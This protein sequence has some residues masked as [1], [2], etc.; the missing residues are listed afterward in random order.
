MIKNKLF[1]NT[2]SQYK[3]GMWQLSDQNSNEGWSD[4]L[5]SL[6]GLTEKNI[7]PSLEYF[8][9][10]ILHPDDITFFKIC[11][12]KY[13]NQAINFKNQ[14]R[15]K[16]S[17]GGFDIYNIF[18]VD[19]APFSVNSNKNLI[20]FQ[21]KDSFELSDNQFHF[22]G[23]S[24]VTNTGSWYVDFK[25]KK[26][27]WDSEAKRILG[28]EEDYEPSMSKSVNYY[29]PEYR[30]LAANTFFN[31]STTG[32]PFKTEIKMLTK[33]GQEIWVNSIGRPIYDENNKIIG[34]KGVFQ[35]IDEIK[36]RELGLK[37]SIEKIASQNDKLF[38]FAHIV[39]HN[40]RSHSSNLNLLVQ[41]IEG[42]EVQNEKLELL[43]EVKTVSNSLTTTIQ[44]LNEIVTIHS[45]TTKDLS[46][47][48][49]ETTLQRVEN[50]IRSIINENDA[51]ITSDFS[52]V[53]SIEYLSAY[54]ESI[55]LNLV[56]NAIKYKHSDRRPEIN[57][58]TQ[59][60]TDGKKQLI[61]KDNGSGINLEKYGKYIFGMYKT[62]HF[63]EDAVGI[64]LF[65]TKNQI[66]SLGGTIEI[67][68]EVDKG[69]SFI[70]TF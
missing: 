46:K 28:Y 24:S 63:N 44:H 23:N 12:T 42:T 35:D 5:L 68:S 15:I 27:Y 66:E 19:E 4:Q 50:T 53:H 38:N 51:V 16:N 57:I 25:N 17:S 47:I 34:L 6:F 69:T 54:L 61:V 43:N 31:C 52:K 32:K 56:T 8:T 55:L 7:T 26:S 65:I 36:Q 30:Q 40:L 64:G 9:E 45:N 58:I 2:L 60:N 13:K 29:A 21:K 62:F 1:L 48:H 49:F 3:I 39:S 18:S 67:E 14:I 41:L 59:L 20:F 33:K 11:Y 37:N 22:K 10:H 70:I